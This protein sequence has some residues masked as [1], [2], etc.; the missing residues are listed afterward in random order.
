MKITGEHLQFLRIIKKVKQ[1]VLARKLG[2]GQQAISKLENKS[3]IQEDRFQEYISALELNREEAITIL[4]L[5]TPPPQNE[6]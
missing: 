4:K 2:V 6:H 1:P 3:F 5:F